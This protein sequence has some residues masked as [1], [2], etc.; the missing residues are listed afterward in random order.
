MDELLSEVT[1]RLTKSGILAFRCSAHSL[2]LLLKDFVHSDCMKEWKNDVR[3]VIDKYS[4]KKAFVDFLDNSQ[5]ICDIADQDRKRVR[6]MTEVRWNSLLDSSKSILA[7]R[8][9]MAEKDK[10]N[11]AF[12]EKTAFF[13]EIAGPIGVLTDQMQRDGSHFSDFVL[14]IQALGSVLGESTTTYKNTQFAA[15]AEELEKLYDVRL[16]KNFCGDGYELFCYFDPSTNHAVRKAEDKVRV[17]K[18]A[19]RYLC[20]FARSRQLV[21]PDAT[22]NEVAQE[23]ERQLKMYENRG[24]IQNQDYMEYWI[25]ST[26]NA[27]SEGDACDNLTILSRFAVSLSKSSHSEA[28]VERH[29]KKLSLHLNKRRGSLSSA[30]ADN[31]LMISINHKQLHEKECPAYS[32]QKMKREEEHLRRTLTYSASPQH[33]NLPETAPE[34]DGTEGLL[35]QLSQMSMQQSQQMNTDNLNDID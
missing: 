12:W 1:E 32:R 21:Y 2:Q 16:K 9:H 27:I 34:S 20:P 17:R 10:N 14:G 33:G 35:Y 8:E 22:D 15:A 23:V 31:L 18:I 5:A 24:F 26:R 7:V 25:G 19:S 11:E 3:D 6:P 28:A 29:F 4:K 13:V 30:R